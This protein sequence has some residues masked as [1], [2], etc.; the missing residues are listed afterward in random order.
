[1]KASPQMTPT[2]IWY[3]D[4]I[5]PF[6]ALAWPHVK[7]LSERT[8]LNLKPVLFAGLLNHWGQLGPAEIPSK[9]I[10]T[11]RQCVW[12]AKEMGVDFRVPDSHPFNPLPYLRLLCANGPSADAVT[13]VFRAIWVDG[14]D[15]RDPKKIE[16]LVQALGLNSYE[17]TQTETL[18]AQLRKNTDEAI[19]AGVFGVPTLQIGS[20]LFW[21]LD[22]LPMADAYLADPACF[23]TEEMRRASETPAAAHR[24][25]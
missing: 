21:G 14:G 2:L 15:P 4:P 22:A 23:E 6:A 3:F 10:Q 7:A 8:T 12:L 5:S 25:R 20:E 17:N 24:P 18:K 9:R 11:Y 1:M 16:T 19:A 13:Q